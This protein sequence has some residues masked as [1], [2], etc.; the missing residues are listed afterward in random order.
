M[1]G[2]I[3]LGS[4]TTAFGAAL[5][6][7]PLLLPRQWF[8]EFGHGDGMGLIGLSTFGFLILGLGFI[9]LIFVAVAKLIPSKN[10]PHNQRKADL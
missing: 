7:G 9:V 10:S 3:R 4:I 5:T 2:A 1:S 6:Y 8:G